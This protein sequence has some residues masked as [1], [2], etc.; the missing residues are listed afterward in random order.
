MTLSPRSAPPRLSVSW[1][2]RLLS[3][4]PIRKP[5]E[6]VSHMIFAAN[7]HNTVLLALIPSNGDWTLTLS[8]VN[9]LAAYPPS[10]LLAFLTSWAAI[11]VHEV[12]PALL[13]QHSATHTLLPSL[14]TL[15]TKLSSTLSLMFG[16]LKHGVRQ[17]SQ[18]SA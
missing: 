16:R 2:P 10:K 18:H 11:L 14:T 1:K 15:F 13:P 3:T 4:L 12:P 8:A 6:L 7:A 5:N 17:T 9:R